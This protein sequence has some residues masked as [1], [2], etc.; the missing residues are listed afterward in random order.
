ML[1]RPTTIVGAVT[2]LGL[3]TEARPGAA[4][5]AFSCAG[6]AQLGGAQLLCSHTDPAAPPQVCT[7]SWSLAGPG[8]NPSVVQGSFL[9]TPGLTNATVYQGNGFA[10]ALANPVVLCQARQTPP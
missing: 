7:F 10:Y 6:F 9:L 4:Q 3:L 2:A 5:P 8:G 1:T